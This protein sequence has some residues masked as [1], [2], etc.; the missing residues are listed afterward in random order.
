[1]SAEILVTGI[2][3]LASIGQGKAAFVDAL[4]DGRSAFGT[5]R[6]P[7]RAAEV[8]FLG[9]ELPE[10]AFPAEIPAQ[11]RRAASLSAQ[12][13][14][15]ALHEA[16]D[17]AGLSVVD[18]TRV[19][20]IV[21]GSNVQQREQALVHESYRDRAG[22][23]RP[24][25]ALGFMDTDLCGFC[26]AQFGIRGPAFTVGGA[27]ASGQLAIA[28]AA[29][30]VASGQVDVCIAIGALMDLSHWE[31]RSLRAI[32][33]MGSDRF[34]DRPDLAC[35]PFDRDRDGFVYGESCA[36]IVLESAD[37]AARR[38]AR[39]EAALRGWGVAVD[40]NRN[41]DPSLEGEMRAIAAA[42]ATAG[43]APSRIDYVNPHGTGSLVGDET[44]LKA[45]RGAGLGHVRLNATKS[46]IGHGLSAAG[47][48]EAA[49]TLLQMR[50]GRLH[51]SRNLDHPID[52]DF[53]WVRATPV[54][55]RIERALT[56][57]MGFGGINTALCWQRLD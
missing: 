6:R 12:A 16:W 10:I 30:A 41:P 46:V 55:H 15:V 31:C 52:A 28:Q 3:V 57:S 33:A 7:G 22:F 42:L 25:Y 49:A 26:T 1:M 51:P 23:L 35:R 36:A 14:L 29:Q 53:A 20:L 5:L 32:G 8:A 4:I 2:G 11:T 21:G 40:A 34:A 19:G 44:E 45:L 47:A 48:V 54:E 38:D 56:L 17:E 37:S 39:A 50:A 13:A 27:S 24:S 9:A 43:W 18:P